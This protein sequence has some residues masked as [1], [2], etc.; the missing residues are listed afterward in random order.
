MVYIYNPRWTWVRKNTQHVL[1]FALINPNKIWRDAWSVDD[2]NVL[3]L[4]ASIDFMNS[5][6]DAKSLAIFDQNKRLWTTSPLDM[7]DSEAAIRAVVNCSREHP[8]TTNPPE[9]QTTSFSGTGF[10][11]G[12]NRLV[13]NY[14]VIKDCRTDVQVRYPEQTP[15]SAKMLGVDETNDLALLH[16]DMSN[17]SGASFRL[18][19]RLGESVATYGFPYSSLLSSGGNFTL[20]NVTA[21]SGMKDDSRFI[22]VSTPIQPGNSGG[23]LLDMSGNVVGMVQSQLNAILMMQYA[24]STPQNVNF[25]IQSAI[26]VNFLSSKGITPQIDNSAARKDVPASDV[27]DLARKFTVQVYCE[28]AKSPRTSQSTPVPSTPNP[29]PN[30]AS[31]LEQQAKQFVLALQAKWSQPNAEAL[32][33]LDAIYDDEVMYFGKKIKRDEVIKE[34]MAF[35]Q[36]YS[37]REYKP[38]DPI[39]VM[40]VERSCMVH[41]FVDFRS[42]DPVAKIMSQGVASFDYQVARSGDSFTIKMENGE[43]LSRIRTPLAQV[44]PDTVEP[45]DVGMLFSCEPNCETQSGEAMESPGLLISVREFSRDLVGSSAN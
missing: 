13:T 2:D 44:S 41:G 8:R 37:K 32:S 16:T 31:S 7:K 24:G 22:Q 11:I 18:G 17:V 9:A 25:A 5:I 23:P 38:K 15:Y 12:S 10:F 34:K 21:L 6:S 42:I 45:R 20:G 27:A 14:H 1:F 3:Y 35:A 39:S 33:G 43:V 26:V 19:P 30:P 4:P 36:R 40:C 29:V 28:A